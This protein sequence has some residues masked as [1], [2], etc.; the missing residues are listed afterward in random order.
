M[1]SCSP[2]LIFEHVKLVL[3]RVFRVARVF[4]WDSGLY[5]RKI[6][7][8]SQQCRLRINEDPSREDFHNIPPY[9]HNMYGYVDLTLKLR[10]VWMQPRVRTQCAAGICDSLQGS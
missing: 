7:A 5:P 1:C 8:Q 3:L 10:L 9:E 6:V 2:L 4:V